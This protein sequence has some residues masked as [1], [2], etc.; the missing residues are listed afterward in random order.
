[1]TSSRDDEHLDGLLADWDRQSN[2]QDRLETLHQQI[3]TAAAEAQLDARHDEP[4]SRRL[5]ETATGFGA[6]RCVRSEQKSWT[7][8]LVV[9]V[10]AMLLVS[11][12]IFLSTSMRRHT[13][14]AHSDVPPG[15]AWLNDD[16]LQNK[17]ALLAEMETLFD[18]QLA[19]VAENGERVELGL[20]DPSRTLSKESAKDRVAIRL[21]VVRRDSSAAN[22]QVAWAMD[23]SAR[24]EEMVLVASEEQ[25]GD[26]LQLWSYELPDGLIAVDCHLRLAGD[27]EFDAKTSTLCRNGQP[28]QI[29]ETQNAGTEYR[30]F[31]TVALLDREVG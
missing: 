24:Q 11:L 12:G 22:W 20:G 31:Q 1:M 10:A 29:L 2:N 27:V 13:T 6:G 8:K 18:G 16:Q 19:W 3:L 4:A 30:M 28:Q 7:A 14:V 26:T 23:V 15:F 17:A 5:P 21:V 25:T 9:A